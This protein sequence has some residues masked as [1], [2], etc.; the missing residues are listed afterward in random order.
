MQFI[1]VVKAKIEPWS[2][3]AAIRFASLHQTFL[4]QFFLSP[5][6][7]FRGVSLPEPFE[8]LTAARF[9]LGEEL[10][11]QYPLILGEV[12][13]LISELESRSELQEHRD[14]VRNLKPDSRS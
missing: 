7:S 12:D 14:A 6:G 4:N 11:P 8:I 1:Q 13:R 5:Q 2:A 9:R 3:L 10:Y